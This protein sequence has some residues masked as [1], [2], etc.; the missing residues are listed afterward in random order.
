MNSQTDTT[1]PLKEQALQAIDRLVRFALDHRLIQAEDAD[2][3]RN[4]LLDMFEQ[5]S[6]R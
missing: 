2:Y 5:A 1:N 4:L 6:L 3:S